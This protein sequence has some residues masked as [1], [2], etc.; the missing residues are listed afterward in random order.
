MAACQTKKFFFEKIG[1]AFSRIAQLI[2]YPHPGIHIQTSEE[3][4]SLGV[5][6]M[7]IK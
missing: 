2:S 5:P 7:I 1:P 6:V 3:R 4:T